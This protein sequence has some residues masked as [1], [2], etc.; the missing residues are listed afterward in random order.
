MWAFSIV[1]LYFITVHYWRRTESVLGVRALCMRMANYDI[2]ATSDAFCGVNKCPNEW[3][4]LRRSVRR[5]ALVR[6][7]IY[8]IVSPERASR[9]AQMKQPAQQRRE[10]LVVHVTR[11]QPDNV[12]SGRAA[13]ERR[14]RGRHS[15]NIV[16]GNVLH[17]IITQPRSS[18]SKACLCVSLF[19]CIKNLFNCLYI[20]ITIEAP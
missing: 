3:W 9:F 6:F 14:T 11:R 15:W 16:T 19:S 12:E 17:G 10:A 1:V 18:E 2:H 20:S 13:H 8:D 4:C 5:S 7:D